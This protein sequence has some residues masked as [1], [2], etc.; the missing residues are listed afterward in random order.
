MADMT[1]RL[2]L[3]A[4]ED[5]RLFDQVGSFLKTTTGTF[6]EFADIQDVWEFLDNH[7]LTSNISVVAMAHNRT[8]GRLSAV[9]IGHGRVKL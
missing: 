5:K 4:T 2:R 7:Y 6:H 3:D 9:L 8:R 1:F